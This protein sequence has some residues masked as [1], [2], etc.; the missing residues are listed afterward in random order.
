MSDQQLLRGTAIMTAAIFASK[1]LGIIYIFPFQAIVGLEG[2]ALYTYGYTPYTIFLSLSTLGIPIAISKFVSKYNTLGDY[3][4][5]RRLF[6]SG[7]VVMTLTGIAAFLMLFFLAEPI[8]KQILNP[9][10]LEGGTSVA[11]AVFTIRMVSV[12]LIIIPVMSSIRGYFQGFGMMGPT[13]ISQVIEQLIRITFIL[14][15]TWLIIDIWGGELGTA[16]GFA[17]FGAF[18]GALG[19]FAV[20]TYFYRRTGQFL[21]DQNVEKQQ[22]HPEQTKREQKSLPEIYKELIAYALPISLVGLAIP[23]YQM[24]DLFTF[25]DAMMAAGFTQAEAINYFGAYGQAVH[26]LVLIPVTIATAM[27]LTIIPTVTSAFTSGDGS[28]LQGQITQIFQV[29]FFFT[30]P[31]AVGLMVLAAP[32]YGTLYSIEDVHIGAPILQFYAPVAILFAVFAVTAALLQGLNRQ[33]IAVLALLIG[34]LAKLVLNIPLITWFGATGAPMATAIGYVLAIALMLWSVA[35]FAR[36][37]FTS[38]WKRFVLITM[39]AA[40]MAAGVLIVRVLLEALTGMDTKMDYVLVTVLSVITGVVI[41][42]GLTLQTGLAQRVLGH[43][44]NRLI[45]RRFR[46]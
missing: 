14:I 31:A 25:N 26:K 29:I 4:T 2:L 16:V 33:K 42:F 40:V 27:S 24:I 43:R 28:K 19:S 36:F 39:F 18:V 23:L 17:T 13:A 21:N 7:L 5:I 22:I 44:I 9:D 1:I 38:V 10:E 30:V 20:L 37:D 41:Y 45:P 6:R 12:A 8:A 15:L 11:D 35:H 34:I 3:D 46:S 32:A